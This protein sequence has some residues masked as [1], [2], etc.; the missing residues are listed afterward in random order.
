MARTGEFLRITFKLSGRDVQS[1]RPTVLA[2][3]EG[4]E[5]CWRGRL[6]ILGLLDGG[7]YF[8]V[9]PLEAMATRV[10]NV[11]KFSGVLA[12]LVLSRLAESIREANMAMNRALKERVEKAA[13]Y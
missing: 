11:E 4:K 10:T 9:E 6:V 7:H 8:R 12:G 13:E 3:E 2:A 1:F 5:L